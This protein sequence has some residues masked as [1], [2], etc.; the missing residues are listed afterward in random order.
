MY[1]LRFAAAMALG[2]CLICA[3]GCAA[4]SPMDKAIELTRNHQEDEAIRVLRTYLDKH[5]DDLKARR[6]LIRVLA[7]T[8]DLGEAKLQIDDLTRRMPANDPTPQ[9]ELGHAYRLA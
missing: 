2:A 5:P 8:G 4:T 7:E 3:A 6:L 1:H 9:I